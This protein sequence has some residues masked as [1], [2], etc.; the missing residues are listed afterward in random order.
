MPPGNQTQKGM[1]SMLR[2]ARLLY[3]RFLVNPRGVVF[4]SVKSGRIE[5]ANPVFLTKT[6]WTLKEYRSRPFTDFIHEDDIAATTQ[7][8]ERMANSNVS[9]GFINR[10]KKPD[11]S[12]ITVKWGASAIVEGYFLSECTFPAEG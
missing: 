6:G 12:T 9:S 8:A 5:Y 3:L 7:E 4:V 10:Y 1:F 11:G 2:L